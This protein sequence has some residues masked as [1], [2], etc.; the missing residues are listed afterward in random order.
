MTQE[1][2]NPL[3]KELGKTPQD[4]TKADIIRF[5]EKRGIQAVNFRYVGGDGRL[6]TLNFVLTGKAQLDE[7][8]SAGERVDGS[9]LFRHVDAASSDLYVVPRFKTAY[10]NPFA[11]V[12][13]LDLLCSYLTRDGVPLANAPDRIVSKAHEVLKEVTGYGLEAMG[14]L[15]YYIFYE[16]QGLYEVPAQRGYHESSPFAK[17]E[18]LRVEAMLAMVQANVSVKYGHAEVGHIPAGST[19]VEQGEVELLPVA[20]ED[21]AD[22]IV[23][24]KWILRMMGRKYGVNITFAPKVMLGHA[25]SGLHI[26][27]RVMKDGRSAM[28]QDG[29]ISEAARKVIAGYLT[30][31]P[32][33]TAFGNTVPTS[34]L[35]LVPHHEAPTHVCWGDSNRSVLVRVPLGWTNVGNLAAVVNPLEQADGRDL[36]QERQTVELR[37]PDGSANAHLLLAGL[38]V[39]ARH[40]L[41]M[42]NSLELC[43][44]LRVEGNVFRGAG[45]DIKRN[46]PRLPASC[47][48]SAKLLLR[49]RSIYEK[50]GVFSPVTVD[51]IAEELKAHEDQDLQTRIAENTELLESLIRRYLHC[52]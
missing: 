31:A 6:K 44:Q 42:Q 34:Y 14:E 29:S 49:D 11:P 36:L 32:S 19:G 51:T 38:A 45:R 3:V 25:G 2:L 37:S 9:S 7:L 30:L 17:W 21:A 24:A 16:Q 50:Y 10:V 33:L 48:E 5:I 35:R 47:W 20:L 41:E 13:T 23:L 4:F 8:L 40:G 39:A 15:E 43:E 28:V 52:G 22:Q 1:F 46:L 26:H 18:Q 27:S 12:P